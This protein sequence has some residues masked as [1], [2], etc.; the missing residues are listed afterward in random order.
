MAKIFI[1]Y[2]PKVESE[3]SLALRLQTLGSLYGLSVSMPDRIGSVV[4]KEAT[5][6]RIDRANLFIVF[7]TRNLT[8]SVINEIEYARSLKKKIIVVYDKD[9]KKNLDIEGVREIE[10]NHLEDKPDKI[11]AEILKEI[12]K[13]VVKSP[14]K[15][16]ATAK[17]DDTLGA[18]L[19][20]GLGLLLLGALT[21]KD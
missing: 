16:L 11:I 15:N 18:F 10:Y 1:S 8:K 2:N 20:V 6:Q 7:S 4:L 12:N 21:S 19:L 13:Q 5:K 17:E 14:R 9:V 3:Q